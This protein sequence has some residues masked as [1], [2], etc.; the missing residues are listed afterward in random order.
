LLPVIF[1]EAAARCAIASQTSRLEDMHCRLDASFR[2]FPDG[3]FATPET[4]P[5][6]QKAPA[7]RAQM[8]SQGKEVLHTVDSPERVSRW[9]YP[10]E[11]DS[12]NDVSLITYPHSEVKHLENDLARHAREGFV[13][14]FWRPLV[15]CHKARPIF[16]SVHESKN[17]LRRLCTSPARR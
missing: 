6:L 12:K 10:A 11:R 13:K 1:P 16:D 3:D 5:A 9:G 14:Y 17:L 8:Q 4:S 15:G 2:S 7:A